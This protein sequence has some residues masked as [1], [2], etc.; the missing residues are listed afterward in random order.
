MLL[1][2]LL[3][4][5]PV[6][7]DAGREGVYTIEWIPPKATRLLFTLHGSKGRAEAELK[8]WL[9]FAK[10]RGF[11]V[12]ALQWWLGGERYL[13]PRE[14]YRILEGRA[15]GTGHLLHGFSR[16]SANV[17]GLAKIDRETGKN[18]FALFVCNSGAW[19]E[20]R[21][22]PYV[23]GAADDA[24]AGQRFVA[25]FGGKDEEWGDRAVR[26]GR[27]MRAFLEQRGA[28][29]E[30]FFELPDGKHGSFAASKDMM[31]ATLDLWLK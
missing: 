2:L 28:R 4:Q 17:P 25:Y 1:L 24:F 26:N 8:D 7:V 18:L 6:R 16:G 29:F 20:D 13:E 21:P 31:N 14:M 9:P 23:R 10:E 27:T 11:G 5:E 19:P 3:A 12:V 15:K 22:P 30:K